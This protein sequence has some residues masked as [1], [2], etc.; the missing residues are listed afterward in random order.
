VSEFWNSPLG[1]ALGFAAGSLLV[2][3]VVLPLLWWRDRRH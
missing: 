2:Y 3:V 1:M